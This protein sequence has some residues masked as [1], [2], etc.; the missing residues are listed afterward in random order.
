MPNASWDD[1]RDFYNFNVGST[2][3]LLRKITAEHIDP[4]KLKMKVSIAAQVFSNTFGNIML[5]CSEHKLLSRDFS[6]T[7]HILVFFNHLFDSLNGGATKTKINPLRSAITMKNKDKIF[8][9]WEYAISMLETMDF[10]DKTTRTVNNGSSV[11]KKTISTIRGFMKLTTLCL[12][13]GKIEM[14]LFVLAYQAF[15]FL[16]LSNRLYIYKKKFD[17]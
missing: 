1:V 6:G 4:K 2:T 13:L 10:I 15:R 12:S 8:E 11:L 5:Y 16:E 9:F 17:I 3:R 14:I 7:G